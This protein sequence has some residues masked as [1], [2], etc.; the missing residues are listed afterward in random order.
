L[1]YAPAT[2]F[3]PRGSRN[4]DD[5]FILRAGVNYRFGTM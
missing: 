5:F 2:A 4:D 3:N 1:F